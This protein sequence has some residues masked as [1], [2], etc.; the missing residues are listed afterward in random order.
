MKLNDLKNRTTPAA[1]KMKE[2]ERRCM[3]NVDIGECNCEKLI[4]RSI[5]DVLKM[6]TIF[7]L[8]E[9]LKSRNKRVFFQI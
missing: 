8:S 4:I 2:S 1:N 7:A 9:A 6:I 3:M 5:M